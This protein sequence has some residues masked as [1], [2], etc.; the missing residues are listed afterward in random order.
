M[1][2]D[3]NRMRNPDFLEGKVAPRGW[4]WVS[5]G[6]RARWN[7]ESCDEGAIAGGVTITSPGESAKALWFQ[8]LTCKP[9]DYY[10]VEATA[11]CDLRAPHEDAGFVLAIEPIKEKRPVGI[12]RVTPAFHRATK[13]I[14]V[15][16]YYEV[17]EG[18]RRIRISVGLENAQGTA[19]IEHVRFIQ[20]IEPEEESHVIAI[21]PPPYASFPPTEV[22]SVLVCSTAAKDRTITRL[23][24]ECFGERHVAVTTPDRFS[25]ANPVEDAL[26]FPDK[27]PPPD[28]QSLSGLFELAHDRIVVISLPA[29]ARLAQELVTVRR[30]EQDD[31]PIHAKVACANFATR[32]F[33]LDDCFPYAWGGKATGSFVQ[34][35]FRKTGR[36]EAFCKEHG[37]SVILVSLC[38]RDA[39]SD[40]PICLYKPTD[41][42][43]LFV[44]DI[45]PVEAP[46]STFGEP[47]IAM[48]LLLSILGREQSSLGQYVVPQTI[49]RRI[50]K[51]IRDAADRFPDFVVHDEDVP[52]EN[53][54]EQ[55]VTIGAEDRTFGM[56]LTPK[57][58]ILVRSGLVSGDVE[59]IYGSLLWFKQLVREE[60]YRCPYAMHLANQFRLAWIPLAAPWESLEGFRRSRRPSDRLVTIESDDKAP[61]TAI[62]V[63][64]MPSAAV[65]LV[66]PSDVDVYRPYGAWLGRL[67]AAF[68]AGN[69]FLP[70]VEDGS[71]FTDRDRFVWR[72]VRHELQV[73]VDPTAFET[74][75]HREVLEGGG[76]ALR[77]EVP[78]WDADFCACS[79]Q[80]TDLTATLL[81][82]VIGLQAGLVAVNR[83]RHPVCL[84]AFPPV[85]PGEALIVAKG[86]PMLRS[87]TQ[88]G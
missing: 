74:D 39:T 71:A 45:E 9:G 84:D 86:D 43:G 73:V 82:Q 31:D 42:G 14:N 3:V 78:G 58:V 28:L 19:R 60:P 59:S 67:T 12:R 80:R 11:S 5:R 22:Q 50:R 15:R 10:R 20:I 18:V 33:A 47:A 79:I 81:E 54:G 44:L 64:S 49:E 21:P 61:T 34:N 17:P 1:A 23:L 16:A 83:H 26:L 63:I 25:A 68:G 48:H 29:F 87:A 85:G 77:I 88:V 56:P 72:H 41:K 66:I 70:T 76:Q 40:K 2:Q 27:T 32:G 75:F 46:C 7:R 62:D 51:I 6:G 55:L 4:S 57:P 69:Y 13:P 52:V 53:V 37:F 38:D 30:I 8:E 36:F 24:A 65:R 35:Q